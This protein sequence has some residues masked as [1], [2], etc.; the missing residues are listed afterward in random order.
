V[1]HF[2]QKFKNLTFPEAVKD[3]QGKTSF[4]FYHPISIKAPQAPKIIINK[5]K[6]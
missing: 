1:I 2:W 4:S 6:K 5:V 3:L